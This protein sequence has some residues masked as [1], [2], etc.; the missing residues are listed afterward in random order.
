MPLRPAAPGPDGAPKVSSTRVSEVGAKFATMTNR[1]DP[2]GRDSR[3]YLD[4]GPVLGEGQELSGEIGPQPGEI[5]FHLENLEPDTE[6][7]C[8]L[9]V[10]NA[11]GTAENAE[12]RFTTLPEGSRGMSFN[13]LRAQA[14]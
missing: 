4:F 13:Q 9:S 10:I 11:N 7:F 2:A 3:Y 1:V 12:G 8:Q 5:E 14:L 6:Y